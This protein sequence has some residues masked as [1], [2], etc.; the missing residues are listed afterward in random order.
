LHASEKGVGRKNKN[1]NKNLPDGKSGNFKERLLNM[2][3]SKKI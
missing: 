3:D 2:A 1:K